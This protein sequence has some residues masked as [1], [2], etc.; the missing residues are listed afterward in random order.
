MEIDKAIPRTILVGFGAVLLFALLAMPTVVGADGGDP[1]VVHACVNPSGLTRIVGPDDACGTNQTSV[2][3]P[4]AIGP[5]TVE[6]DCAIGQTISQALQSLSTSLTIVVK[7]TCNENVVVAR[8]VV[9]LQADP[10]A[11]GT[12]NGPV[13][14]LATITVAGQ[15]VL[16]DG[17]Q[18]TGGRNGIE[19]VGAARLTIQNCL[20]Q[21]TGRNGIAFLQGTSGTVNHC[22]VQNN[23]R[24][25]VGVFFGSSATVINSTITGNVRRGVQIFQNA[26]ALV[27]ITPTNQLAGNT[28]SNNGTR[29]IAV[30][31]GSSASIGGNTISGNGT[32]PNAQ[33]GASD[34]VGIFVFQAV[35]DI[36]GGNTIS[37]N[38]GSGVLVD[39]GRALFGDAGFGFTTVNTVTGNGASVLPGFADGGV[40][41]FRAGSVFIRDANINGNTGNGVT[42]QL[43]S[44]AQLSNSTVNNNT[45]NGILVNLGGALLLGPGV[46]VTGNTGF[47]LL[48]FNPESSFAGNVSGITGNTAG[49]VSCTG[50]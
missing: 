11:G 2:H 4:K 1:N 33:F 39:D 7:G 47:G 19:G 35:A 15:D 40:F 24:D 17:L 10:V 34:R 3:W 30:I 28:I 41:V 6:V 14:T 13:S 21:N 16:I 42:A 29:G 45:A 8:D 23:V 12:V 25:G 37:G 20:V 5:S 46:T 50:F 44:T 32:N 9:T 18:V 49:Q 43:R 26:N 22:T 27:G 48:C 31:T 38:A 36:A